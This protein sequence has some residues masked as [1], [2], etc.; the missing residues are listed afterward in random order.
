MYLP[1][2]AIF[3]SGFLV[4]SNAIKQN[5]VPKRGKERNVGRILVKVGIAEINTPSNAKP[6]PI[7][8]LALS[9]V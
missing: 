3:T 8:F 1:I 7:G 2:T 5:R 6:F 4:A 9:T